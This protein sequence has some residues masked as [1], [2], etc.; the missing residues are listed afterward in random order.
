MNKNR[1]DL[2]INCLESLLISLYNLNLRCICMSIETMNVLAILLFA[3]LFINGVEGI[4][5]FRLSFYY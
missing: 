1:D 2:P 5:L 3:I 4:N